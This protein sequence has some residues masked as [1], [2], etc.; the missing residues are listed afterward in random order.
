MQRNREFVQN[1]KKSRKF[2][3]LQRTCS[4]CID[5]FRDSYSDDEES[6]ITASSRIPAIK[7]MSIDSELS[8]SSSD[9][10][11]RVRSAS[12]N[13]DQ[14]KDPTVLSSKEKALLVKESFSSKYA[15]V[16]TLRDGQIEK[17][18]Q[19][20]RAKTEIFQKDGMEVFN[21]LKDDQE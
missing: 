20:K 10:N 8:S 15:N 6:V 18:G 13:E 14:S 7:G 5:W 2:H 16:G 1:W 3:R 11:M 4:I 17:L 9:F 12:V 19:K 21:K